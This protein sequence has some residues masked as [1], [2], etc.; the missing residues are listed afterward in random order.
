MVRL[1]AGCET[2]S[3]RPASVKLRSSATLRKTSSWCSVTFIRIGYE[4]GQYMCMSKQASR[5]TGCGCDHSLA[6][7]AGTLWRLIEICY[8]WM[9]QFYYQTHFGS[10]T[11]RATPDA[12]SPEPAKGARIT[13]RNYEKSSEGFCCRGIADRHERHRLRGR[14]TGGDQAGHALR[15]VRALRQHLHARP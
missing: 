5:S 1:S 9:R 8:K 6:G 3:A 2:L 11:M 13:G 15:L 4:Y 7:H 14:S 10:A 12:P